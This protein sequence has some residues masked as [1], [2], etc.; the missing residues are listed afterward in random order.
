MNRTDYDKQYYQDNK[1]KKNLDSKLWRDN[2][3]KQGLCVKCN[4]PVFL[5]NSAVCCEV[6]LIQKRVANAKNSKNTPKLKTLWYSIS[7]RC[8]K[9]NREYLSYSAFQS[10]YSKQVQ[11]C[12]YCGVRPEQL[13][14]PIKHHND[15]S[16][17]RMNNSKGYTIDNICL[18]C[19]KC[20]SNKGEFFTWQEWQ[21][22]AETVIR[23][24]LSDYHKG[25]RDVHTTNT[26]FL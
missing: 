18:C 12:C 17:D 22:I 16:I 3:K 11:Q 5:P 6:H 20:N 2:R 8:K 21:H 7:S 14:Y 1:A 10:W 25:L 9:R 4:S 26:L 23:P 19:H 15:M 13:S 24:R